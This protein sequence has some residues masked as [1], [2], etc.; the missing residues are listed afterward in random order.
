MNERHELKMHGHEP[1]VWPQTNPN[2]Y[3]P[4]AGL[5]GIIM[6]NHTPGILG[7]TVGLVARDEHLGWVFLVTPIVMLLL[8]LRVLGVTSVRN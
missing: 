4:L 3:Q 1:D 6:G 2:S 8:L 7:E 5:C